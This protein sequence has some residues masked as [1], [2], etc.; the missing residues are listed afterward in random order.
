MISNA[1]LITYYSYIPMWIERYL[2]EIKSIPIYIHVNMHAI[3]EMFYIYIQEKRE[4]R[5][6]RGKCISLY[7]KS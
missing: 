4:R 5:E 1:R 6:R 7:F 3:F 2:L